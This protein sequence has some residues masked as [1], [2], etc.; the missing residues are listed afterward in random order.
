MMETMCN[1][2]PLFRDSG[3][4]RPAMAVRMD[5]TESENTMD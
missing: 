4:L 1:H 2:V 3:G 5:T